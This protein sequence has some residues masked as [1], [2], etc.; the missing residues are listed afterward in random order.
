MAKTEF[1]PTGDSNTAYFIGWDVGGWNCDRNPNSRDA[2]VILDANG[3]LIG[4][5]WRGNLRKYINCC[6][7]SVKWTEK[8]FNLCNCKVTPISGPVILAVDTPLGFPDAFIKLT[9]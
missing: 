1:S 8:L 7:T 6:T 9:T 2:I 3:N 5:P 4:T